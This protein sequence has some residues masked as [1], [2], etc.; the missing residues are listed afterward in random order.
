MSF[1]QRLL[2]SNQA[3]PFIMAKKLLA[4]QQNQCVLLRVPQS[5]IFGLFGCQVYVRHVCPTMAQQV[6]HIQFCAVLRCATIHCRSVLPGRIAVPH[7]VVC[8]RPGIRPL[9]RTV[10]PK[11][12]LKSMN[13][14]IRGH[15]VRNKQLVPTLDGSFSIPQRLFC[16][17]CLH[18]HAP[19]TSA[20]ALDCQQ[21]RPLPRLH[22]S[23][24]ETAG[25]M[26]T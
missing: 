8:Q 17:S 11:E 20:L 23:R 19:D 14:G 26:D 18:R 12:R 5:L 10:L 24:I 22:G 21:S 9:V 7:P 1:W 16:C 2:D 6:R 25:L 3:L 13:I 15:I 4:N